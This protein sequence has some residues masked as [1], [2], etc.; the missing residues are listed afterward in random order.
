MLESG[1]TIQSI[2]ALSVRE[3]EFYAVVKGNAVGHPCMRC[4]VESK[5]YQR[6]EVRSECIGTESLQERILHTKYL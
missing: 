2:K 6:Q 5:M 1:L 4:Q 3:A